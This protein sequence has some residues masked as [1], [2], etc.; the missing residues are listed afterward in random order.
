M[1]TTSAK[2]T[3]FHALCMCMKWGTDCLRSKCQ[4]LLVQPQKDGALGRI[5]PQNLV[6]D[7]LKEQ[8][9]EGVEH[10]SKASSNNAGQPLKRIREVRSA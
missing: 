3:T 9:A 4:R 5:G 10:A 8:D 2:A 1:E 7:G 6:E